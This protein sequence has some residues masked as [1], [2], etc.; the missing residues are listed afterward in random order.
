MTTGQAKPQ[1]KRPEHLDM[2]KARTVVTKIVKENKEWL[3]EM[4]DK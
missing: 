3:K 4:A 1:I 2:K